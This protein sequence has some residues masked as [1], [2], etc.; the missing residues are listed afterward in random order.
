MAKSFSFLILI[1]GTALAYS[2]KEDTLFSILAPHGSAYIYSHRDIRVDPPTI[3]PPGECEPGEHWVNFDNLLGHGLRLP[4]SSYGCMRPSMPS[5]TI[6]RI[7]G[8]KS[9]GKPFYSRITC[10]S[11]SPDDVRSFYPLFG[12]S[13]FKFDMKIT[14]HT[15]V[16]FNLDPIYNQ[17]NDRKSGIRAY[18]AI[19]NSLSNRGAS[20]KDLASGH[21]VFDIMPPHEVEVDTIGEM[22]WYWLDSTHWLFTHRIEKKV[23]DGD[24][25]TA[26]E[27]LYEYL[28]SEIGLVTPRLIRNTR[29][30]KSMDWTTIYLKDG[31]LHIDTEVRNAENHFIPVI[32]RRVWHKGFMGEA[33]YQRKFG[34]P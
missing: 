5:D 19:F 22:R 30:G 3:P 23:E 15:R 14:K 34:K 10:Y 31:L 27:D 18:T 9:R 29:S 11:N 25:T 20:A 26:E 4:P 33:D 21:G 13:G 8:I 1:L 28:G 24:S 7:R 6:Y 12:G 16:R 32:T 2:A 17:E